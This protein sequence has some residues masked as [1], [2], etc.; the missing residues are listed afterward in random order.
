MTQDEA[1]ESVL[2]F[3]MQAWTL[4]LEKV[5]QED[6]DGPF[7]E[8]LRARFEIKFRYAENGL[9][10]MWNPGDDID[11]HFGSVKFLSISQGP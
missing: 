6:S 4:F 10:R 8:K 11:G 7:L 9:P 5:A 2:K 3:K 1:A